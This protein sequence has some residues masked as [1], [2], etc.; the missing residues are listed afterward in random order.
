MPE[1]GTLYATRLVASFLTALATALAAWLVA[2]TSLALGYRSGTALVLSGVFGVAT[3]AWPFSKTWF[4]EP[5]VAA[6]VLL[7]FDAG[8]R[9]RQILQSREAWLGGGRSVLPPCSASLA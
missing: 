9:A 1:A 4:S 5:A 6:L 8:L 3:M 2:D 7:S